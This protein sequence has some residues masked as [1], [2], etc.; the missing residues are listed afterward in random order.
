MSASKVSFLED[1]GSSMDIVGDT[2]HTALFITQIVMCVKQ[3][4]LEDI[5]NVTTSVFFLFLLWEFIHKKAQNYEKKQN[6]RRQ[7]KIH[8][9][10]A[11]SLLEWSYKGGRGRQ[12]RRVS[13]DVPTG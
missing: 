13:C 7:K 3:F 5:L 6:K 12:H 8:I 2:W 1:F 9:Q 10:L 11:C 4:K